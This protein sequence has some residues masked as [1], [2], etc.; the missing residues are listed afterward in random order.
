[1]PKTAVEAITERGASAISAVLLD[2]KAGHEESLIARE[3]SGYGQYDA[4]VRRL[5]PSIL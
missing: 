1:L 3:I 4:K 5:I 2:A